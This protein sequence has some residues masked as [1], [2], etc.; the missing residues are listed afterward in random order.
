MTFVRGVIACSTSRSSMFSV[1]GRTSTNFSVAPR[2]RKAFAVETNVC[3]GR[4]T[5]SPGSTSHS[6]A[7][8]SKADVHEVVSRTRVAPKRCSISCWHSRVNGPSPLVLPLARQRAISSA[9][10]PTRNGLLNGMR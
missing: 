3:E 8:I 6:N 5:S 4:M 2:N 9:S 7:A 1:S 10:S